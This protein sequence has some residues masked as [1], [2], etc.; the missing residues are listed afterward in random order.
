M[1]ANEQAPEICMMAYYRKSMMARRKLREGA[2]TESIADDVLQLGRKLL[3]DPCDRYYANHVEWET[4]R[5]LCEAI[6]SEIELGH[7]DQAERLAA[8][9]LGMLSDSLTQPDL[10][11]R[12]KEVGG[13]L[14]YSTGAI[15]AVVRSDHREAIRWYDKAI[16]CF[17]DADEVSLGDLGEH[18]DRLVS[19]GLSYW[20]TGRRQEGMRL[21]KKGTQLIQRAVKNG[22]V[23]E[24]ALAVPY[25]NLS[26][27]HK[28]LGNHEESKSFAS[29]AARLDS[30]PT[31]K[32]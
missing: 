18:G 6:A 10:P 7:A 31:T 9:G 3:A 2:D 19:I 13:R 23:P 16:V 1:V 12:L 32:R 25:G 11:Q 17:P 8:E 30:K 28:Q 26:V 4:G 27:M 15:L 20:S 22:T 5:T 21:T 24:R 29:M 14:Y